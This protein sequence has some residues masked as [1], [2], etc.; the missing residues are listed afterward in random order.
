MMIGLSVG[1]VLALYP[2]IL[3]LDD[4]DLEN[5][6]LFFEKLRKW[7]YLLCFDLGRPARCSARQW[8]LKLH[9]EQVLETPFFHLE[10]LRDLRSQ[11]G[12]R[13]QLTAIKDCPK[14]ARP[15]PAFVQSDATSAGTKLRGAALVGRKVRVW[16]DGDEAWYVGVVASF[17]SRRGHVVAYEDGEVKAHALDD[18]EEEEWQML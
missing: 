7:P 16:W 17:A 11:R 8:L 1:R 15:H 10:G 6:E 4:A 18:S 5:L 2:E 12:K 3:I 13:S 14:R 9:L